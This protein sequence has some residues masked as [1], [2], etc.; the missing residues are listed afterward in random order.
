[1]DKPFK[2]IDQQIELLESRGVATDGDSRS[3]LMREGYYP[4]VNGYKAPFIDSVATKEAGDDRYRDGTRFSDMHEL[5][6]FDRDL[7]EAGV[8]V[9]QGDP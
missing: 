2:S 8:C 3:I 7:R 5:F 9:R 1:M 6:L 4:I